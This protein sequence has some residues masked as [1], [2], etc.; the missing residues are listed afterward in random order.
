MSSIKICEVGPRDGLQNIQRII[1]TQDKVKLIELLSAANLQYIELSSFV[2]P[3]AIPQLAD[4]QEVVEQ[5]KKH[6]Q[7]IDTSV[8]VPHKIITLEW[9]R[10]SGSIP[11]ALPLV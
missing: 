10:S 11:A 1:P 6:T 9:A 3:K 7:N 4:A 8:L 5:S 2:S